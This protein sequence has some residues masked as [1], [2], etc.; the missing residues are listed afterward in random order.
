MNGPSCCRLYEGPFHPCNQN[1]RFHHLQLAWYLHLYQLMNH[2]RFS[3]SQEGNTSIIISPFLWSGAC[4]NKLSGKMTE[5]LIFILFPIIRGNCLHYIPKLCMPSLG[6]D[7]FHEFDKFNRTF[8]GK[9]TGNGDLRTL[10]LYY[11]ALCLLPKSHTNSSHPGNIKGDTWL[12]EH[13]KL[14]Y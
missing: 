10:V 8:N 6:Q 14:N 12:E 4:I 1:Q 13:N 11:W 7:L 3:I 9:T 2:L 5:L